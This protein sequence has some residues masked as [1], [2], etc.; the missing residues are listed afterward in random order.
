VIFEAGQR[1][2]F[3]GDSITDAGRR[4]TDP[5]YGHG[6]VS[7]VR[8]LV[9]ASHPELRL[10]WLNR[11]V[12]GD[13]VRDLARR[14]ERDV[15]AARPD[16]LSV[17]I[18]INDVWRSFDG[19]P[20]EAVPVDEYEHTLRAL[21]G[22]A[23]EATGCR[24]ILAEPYVI[25]PDRAEPQRARTDRYAAVVRQVAADLDAILVRTQKAF[26]RVLAHSGPTDWATDRIH[27]ELA[28]HAVIAQEYLRAIGWRL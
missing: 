11:G 4:D 6:Y 18:G 7:L 17:K 16:W 15:V 8:A 26:D 3:A 20:A 5:P 23:V 19:R 9:T 22:H 12:G 1:I 28:G 2:V 24:L 10:T 25:E 27:P 13:T 14:W 21:L